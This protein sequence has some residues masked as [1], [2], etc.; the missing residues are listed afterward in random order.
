ME[1]E[2]TAFCLFTNK[3]DRQGHDLQNMSLQSAGM[4]A[5]SC[6]STEAENPQKWMQICLFYHTEYI[7][8]SAQHVCVYTMYYARQM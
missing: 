1:F 8:V 4:W 2:Q 3:K 7:C 6:P 5:L